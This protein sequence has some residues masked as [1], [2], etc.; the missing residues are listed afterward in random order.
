MIAGIGI[1]LVEISRIR[2]SLKRFGDRFVDRI[3]TPSEAGYCAS[4]AD[5]ALH[6]AARFA[7][8]EAV[9]K[10][11]GTGIGIDL[12]WHDVEVVR[13]PGGN[14]EVR[15]IGKGRLFA[16]SK[17]ISRIHLSLTHTAQTAAA[18]VIFESGEKN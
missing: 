4:C 11:L 9:G 8:K 10:A 17:G 15:L 12:A 6:V 16:D 2:D 1:D 18:V 7:A 14:P 13:H 3:L 5:P